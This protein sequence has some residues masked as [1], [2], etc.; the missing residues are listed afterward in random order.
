MGEGEDEAVIISY[1]TSLSCNLYLCTDTIPRILSVLDSI[2]IV[3]TIQDRVR[4]TDTVTL[5]ALSI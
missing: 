3:C 1:D 2:R 5:C 4:S